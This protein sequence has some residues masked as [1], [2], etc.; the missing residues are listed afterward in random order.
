MTAAIVIEGLTRRYGARTVVDALD[1]TIAPGQVFGFLGPNGAGKTTTL[2]MLL[3]LVRPSSGSARIFGHD[4]QRARVQALA[5]VGALVETPPIYPYLSGRDNLRV[6]ARAGGLPDARVDAVI[7]TVGLTERARDAARGYSQG[8]RQRLGIARALLPDPQ[9]IVLDEPT[10]GL[11][12]AG[13][14]AMRALVTS[15]ARDGRTVVVSSHILHDIEQTCDTVAILH[16]GRLVA[17]G[18]LADLLRTRRGVRVRVLGD[19][20]AAAAL[21]RSIAGV[22]GVVVEGDTLMV[23]ADATLAPVI[24]AAL[25]A[26]GIGIAEVVAQRAALEDLFLELTRDG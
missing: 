12:P 7:E 14:H 11:D 6:A 26:Q 1:L 5:R 10:N 19:G 24:T 3:G 8:M 22:T 15:L 4:C 17:H 16:R 20:A 13:Q 2:A 18:A 25:A 21:V 23:D 9:L